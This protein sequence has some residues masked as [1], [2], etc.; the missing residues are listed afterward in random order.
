MDE[1]SQLKPEDAL[2]AIARGK[3]VIIVGDRKQLPPTSFFDRLGDEDTPEEDDLAQM[4]TESESILDVAS[5]VYTPAR[6]LKWHYRSHV[7]D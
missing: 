7:I 2:G 3:Q 5:A 4:L 1:A 6:M